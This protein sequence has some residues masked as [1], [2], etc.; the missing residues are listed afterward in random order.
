MI[1]RFCKKKK[2]MWSVFPRPIKAWHYF[3]LDL[4][5]FDDDSIFMRKTC[6]ICHILYR[7]CFH[8]RQTDGLKTVK[9]IAKANSI[10]TLGNVKEIINTLTYAIFQVSIDVQTGQ[11]CIDDYHHQS[12]VKRTIKLSNQMW[13]T[14][15]F[16]HKIQLG[17]KMQ[18]FGIEYDVP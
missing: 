4:H 9:W 13:C 3:L 11:R 15:L 5:N 2:Q 12:K 1:L 6:N 17:K 16:C 18:Y 10:S 7:N 14:S 8:V